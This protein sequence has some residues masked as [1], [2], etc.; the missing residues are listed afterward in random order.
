MVLFILSLHGSQELVSILK[1]LEDP[2]YLVNESG[3]LAEGTMSKFLKGNKYNRC[4]RCHVMLAT[5]FHILHFQQF[6]KDSSFDIE[7]RD[8][9]LDWIY[10]GNEQTH[11]SPVLKELTEKY[12]QY[13]KE[14]LD[15]ER[16][17]TAQ[18][19]M[20]YC[21]FIELYLILHRAVK[22]NDVNL[23][24]YVMIEMCCLFFSTNQFNYAK[25]MLLYSLELLNLDTTHP[26]I[27]ELLQNGGF[28][29]RRSEGNFV[30][31]GVDMALEQSNNAHAKHK[32]RGTV[33]FANNSAAVQ[34]WLITSTSKT[35]SLNKLDEIGH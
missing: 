1:G 13:C 34:R 12:L 4:K 28:S 18:F 15:G 29:V 9:L 26:G 14:S 32:L 19:W 2:I 23:F 7:F 25:W 3:V 30:R 24:A 10:A 20:Q 35:Q 31:V 21:K 33:P 5:S 17:D 8:D 11:T 6:L 16:G 27:L 22:M